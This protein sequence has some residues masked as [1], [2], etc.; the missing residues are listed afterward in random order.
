MT[1]KKS[2]PGVSESTAAELHE[3][4]VQLMIM[5]IRQQLMSGEINPA[6]VRNCLQYLKQQAITVDA[7]TDPGTISLLNSL[8]ELD[9]E[10]L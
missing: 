7:E 1:K 10:S 9:L 5:D 4:T 8:R 3:L 2:K 6:C